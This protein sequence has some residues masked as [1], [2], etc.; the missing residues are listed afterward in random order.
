MQAKCRL[1]RISKQRKNRNCKISS[2]GQKNNS[3]LTHKCL[4]ECTA[5]EF[6][7]LTTH[8]TAALQYRCVPHQTNKCRSTNTSL[9]VSS[10]WDVFLGKHSSRSI[11]FFRADIG[12]FMLAI[13]KGNT[14]TKW[15]LIFLKFVACSRLLVEQSYQEGRWEYGILLERDWGCASIKECDHQFT[16][17]IRPQVNLPIQGIKWNGGWGFHFWQLTFI[18]LWL[19]DHV[20]LNNWLF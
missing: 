15:L 4:P 3:I 14:L 20:I 6:T 18:K 11:F 8:Q 19:K 13:L 1:T 17:A 5:D 7:A 9:S 12:G 16:Y 2:L 10:C